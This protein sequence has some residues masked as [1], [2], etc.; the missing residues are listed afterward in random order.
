MFK[1]CACLGVSCLTWG[2]SWARG[3]AGALTQ[4][5]RWLCGREQQH[6]Q[7]HEEEWRW[8][9]KAGEKQR[10]FRSRFNER[11]SGSAVPVPSWKHVGVQPSLSWGRAEIRGCYAMRVLRH[12]KHFCECSAPLY[13]SASV[14]EVIIWPYLLL[15]RQH[16]LFYF[17]FSQTTN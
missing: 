1:S 13:M 3:P 12:W 17:C 2:P 9:T 16:C 6:Q 4:S 15:Q 8:L 14:R 11:P 5:T 10:L 7:Q